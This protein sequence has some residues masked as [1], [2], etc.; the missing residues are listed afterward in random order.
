MMKW[1]AIVA[2]IT[3]YAALLAAVLTSQNSPAEKWTIVA[4]SNGFVAYFG[5]MAYG[6]MDG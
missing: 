6:L 2:G 1:I 3:G 5:A 4:M